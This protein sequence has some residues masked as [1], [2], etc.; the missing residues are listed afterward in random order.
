[1]S[2]KNQVV[3]LVDSYKDKFIQCLKLSHLDIHWHVVHS[4]DKAAIK[5]FGFTRGMAVAQTYWD[6]GNPKCKTYHIFIYY[7]LQRNRKFTI[8][9]IFHEL[10]HVRL[11]QW[12]AI[13]KGKF[14]ATHCRIEENLIVDLEKILVD[15]I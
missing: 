7:D 8:G 5:K 1:M 4:D 14:G 10:L 2:T 3:K 9:S 13:V 6:S 15:L 12:D 11:R